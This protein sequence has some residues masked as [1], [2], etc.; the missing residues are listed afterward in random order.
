MKVIIDIGE[1][2][3][4]MI[5]TNNKGT[6]LR[7]GEADWG[8]SANY[9]P[10]AIKKAAQAVKLPICFN[11]PSFVIIGG[12][13]VILRRFT[14]PNMSDSA[15]RFNAQTEIEPILPGSLSDFIIG[16]EV[17]KKDELTAEVLV[18]ATPLEYA[19]MIINAMRKAGFKAIRMAVREQ[20]WAQW[21]DRSE[22]YAVLDIC[23]KSNNK[24]NLAIY[25][26]GIFYS[27]RHFIV[28]TINDDNEST[29]ALL[30]EISVTIDYIHYKERGSNVKYILLIGE[31]SDTVQNLTHKIKKLQIPILMLFEFP[32]RRPISKRGMDLR[33]IVKVNPVRQLALP[34]A[35]IFILLFALLYLGTTIQNEEREYLLAQEK[36]LQEQQDRYVISTEDVMQLNQSVQVIAAQNEALDNFYQEYPQ[37]REVI[38]VMLASGLTVEGLSSENGSLTLIGTAGFGRL[39][40]GVLFLRNHALV[41]SVRLEKAGVP[42]GFIISFDLRNGA[43]K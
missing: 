30:D 1:S 39:A 28:D 13:H 24:V 23:D 5:I 31:K 37:A 2:A 32:A 17:L 34:V 11:M 42:D 14:W 19:N 43:K 8:G 4:S 6:V 26:G 41:E 3:V 7:Q 16:C 20:L 35:C 12:S 21:A 18:A 36:W 22:S 29:T 38:P 9:L 10:I 15:L 33:P 25:L 40:E 27:N